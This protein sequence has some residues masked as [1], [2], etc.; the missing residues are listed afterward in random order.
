MAK[1]ALLADLHFGMRNDSPRFDE[2]ARAFF[3]NTFFPYLAEAGDISNIIIVGDIFERRKYI[4]F[5]TLYN[6]REYF[7][8]PLVR[9]NIPT[10]AFVGNHDVYYK[11]TNRVNSLDLLVRPYL[12]IVDKPTVIKFPKKRGSVSALMVPWITGDNFAE[13]IDTIGKSK[14]DVCFGHFEIAGFEMHKG[15]GAQSGLDAELFSNFKQV[16]TG[17]FH[18][19]STRGNINYL[20]SPYEMNWNDFEDT[21]GFHV[22]DTDTLKMQFIANEDTMHHKIYYDDTKFMD[23]D[24]TRYAGK[25]VRIMVLKKTDFDKFDTFIDNLYRNNVFD[26]NIMEDHASY[27]IEET[28]GA[29][30]SGQIEVEDTLTLLGEQ[31]DLMFTHDD[32][33]PFPPEQLKTVLHEVFVEAQNMEA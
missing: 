33:I 16:F 11:N 28:A 19:K 6:A 29:V 2:N 26:L 20:G 31:V 32:E 17:H 30:G 24:A 15:H 13:T 7:F 21:R 27:S 5:Q 10:Y 18:H 23:L 1:I 3:T 4:N 9:T 12:K 8:E 14:A 25:S 22:L